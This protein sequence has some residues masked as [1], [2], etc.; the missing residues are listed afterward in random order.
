[1]FWRVSFLALAAYAGFAVAQSSTST[2]VLGEADY[3]VVGGGA[4]GMVAA[5]RLSETGASVI[6][7]ERGPPATY[8]HGGSTDTFPPPSRYSTD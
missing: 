5:D 1:M 7:I 6:L 4:G 8:A 3:I 2:V